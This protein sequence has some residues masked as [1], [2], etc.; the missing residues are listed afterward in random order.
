MNQFTLIRYNCVSNQFN[1]KIFSLIFSLTLAFSAFAQEDHLT[2]ENLWKL[3]R[4]YGEEVSP[5]GKTVMYLQKKYDLTANKGYAE[6]YTVSI[7]GGEAKMISETNTPIFEAHWRPDGKKIGFTSSKSGSVQLWEMNPDGT[8]AEQVSNFDFDLEN[9]KYAPDMKHLSFSIEVEME[10]SLTKKYSDLDKASGR[11][12]DNLMFRHWTQW[13]D[14][15]YSHVAYA[16]IE[17]GKVSK[18]YVDI[19]PE[20]RADS[21]MKPFGGSEQIVWTKD[22]NSIIYVSKKLVGKDYA[23]STNSELYQYNL[24]TKVTLNITQGNMGYDNEPVVSPDGDMIAWVAMAR[25]GF[26]SDK[27]VVWLFDLKTRQKQALTANIDQ[28]FGSLNWSADQ[29]KIYAVSGVNATFQIFE[30][31]LAGK[32]V[33]S[34]T[35]TL[36]QVTEGIHDI[37]GCQVAG[38]KLIG[39]KNSMSAPAEIFA[40]D[41]K[42]G[43]ATQ[44][45]HAND[46]MMANMKMGKVEKR[47]VKTSDGKEMLTWVI[48][49]PDFDPTK[50]YPTLLY[51]QGGPQSA[52]SQFFSY[53]WNF[54][55]MA[56]N[57]YIVVAPNRRGLPSF[58]QEWNDEISKDWG[59]QAMKDYL[60]AIDDVAKESYVNRDKLGAV[61]ASYGGYSV[62][63]LAGI[64]DGRFK[65]FI[66]HCG[67]FNLESWYASTEELFF[68]NWDIGGPYWETPQPKSY[69]LFSPNK[70]VQN[71]DTPIMVIHNELDFRVPLNQGLEAFTAAQ[72]QGI[73][74]K[75]LYYPDEGHWVVKPQNGVMWHREFYAWLDQWLK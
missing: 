34:K 5:D 2:P 51:C 58:G 61:G 7:N 29:K 37:H 30:L 28:S 53:R 39:S 71:W 64:H 70:L 41:G 45:S 11:A 52:V 72:L 17:N 47:M 13:H 1:M 73:P 35:C 22:G 8:D 9:W 18:E 33:G 14:Y 32:E 12:Y 54:Q 67:L 75:L 49:P 27:N 74:S 69:Q 31:T 26:E 24:S 65:T 57:G 63:Y 19:M 15:K 59:G 23:V 36:R 48:L 50:K 55:L 16:K 20:D 10:E 40:F 4:V 21:P 38:S 25:D 43:K 3:E 68:A 46:A 62:Y 66:S 44:L 6:I 42:S 56:A 60:A